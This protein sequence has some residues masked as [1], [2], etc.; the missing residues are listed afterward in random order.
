MARELLLP[1]QRMLLGTKQNSFYALDLFRLR[2]KKD[3]M[4]VLH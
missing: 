3:Y 2:E 4:C 1:V